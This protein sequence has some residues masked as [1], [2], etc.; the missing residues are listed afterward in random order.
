LPKYT[1]EEVQARF[2]EFDIHASFREGRDHHHF[3]TLERYTV[4]SLVFL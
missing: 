4:P 2:T 1:L 3:M